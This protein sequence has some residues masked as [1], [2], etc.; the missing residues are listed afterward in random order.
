MS[1]RKEER[2]KS[3]IFHVIFRASF[4]FSSLL[5]SFFPSYFLSFPML[6]EQDELTTPTG[7]ESSEI[8]NEHICTDADMCATDQ[9]LDRM[10]APEVSVSSKKD[11]RKMRMSSRNIVLV[12]VGV[13][14]VL[15]GVMTA[16]VYT[17]ASTDKTVRALTTRLPFPAIMIGRSVVTYKAYYAEQDSLKK[18]FASSVAQGTEAP[19]DDQLKTMIVQ[20]LANKAVVRKLAS[21]YGVTLDPAKVEEFYQNFLQSNAG[22]SEEEVKKQLQ[23]TFGWTPEQFKQRIVQPIVLSTA[24]SEFV[25]KSPFF[26]EPVKN[27]IDSAFKRITTG[28]EDFE[29]VGNEVHTRVQVDLKSDL[30]FIKKSELPDSWGSKVADLENGKTTDVID[31][32]QGYA[33]FKVSD[34]IKSDVTPTKE[35]NADVKEEAVPADDQLHLLTITVPKKTLDQIIQNYLKQVP[36]RVL[37]KA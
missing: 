19:T 18:Y 20:T 14:V 34:R 31:L 25:S 5:L 33:I 13:V 1:R 8:G 12:V 10:V 26:Q 15:F 11:K 3:H 37:I 6:N 30:G 23:D 32:P 2:K 7:T 21:D 35:K 4:P 17:H 16:Y 27:E 29:T 22:A 36:P 28:G 9:S 24:V